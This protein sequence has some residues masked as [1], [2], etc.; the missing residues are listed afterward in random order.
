MS[1]SPSNTMTI[2]EAFPLFQTLALACT[3]IASLWLCSPARASDITEYDFRPQPQPLSTRSKLQQFTDRASELAVSAMGMIGIHYKYGGNNPE[4]GLDCS[5]LV[6]YVFKDAWGVNV[7]RT[8]AELSRSGEKIDK[9]DL[10]PGDLVFYNTLRRSFSHVGIYLGD[11]K[12]IHAPSAGGKVRIE[13]MDLAYWKS[14]FN[15]AR[16]INDPEPDSDNH[17]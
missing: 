4:N 15:G 14:R 2:K 5:G 13:S 3:L 12:F 1:Q 11:N 17:Q 9:Q 8:A 16:R 7:P 10:Q 6:R